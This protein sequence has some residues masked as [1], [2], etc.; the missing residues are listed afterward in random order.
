[1]SDFS[2]FTILEALHHM[3]AAPHADWVA[4]DPK[5][6]LGVGVYALDT[7]KVYIGDG[8]KTYTQLNPIN[9]QAI[10]PEFK[11]MLDNAGLANG[12]A[13]L[14]ALGKVDMSNIPGSWEHMTVLYMADIAARDAYPVE[15]RNDK[16]F[17][18]MDASADPT[19]N[20]GAAVYGWIDPIGEPDQ[21][22][23]VKIMEKESLDVD[24]SDLLTLSDGTMDMILAGTNYVH[25]TPTMRAKLATIEENADVTDTEN[26]TAAGA[27]MYPIDTVVNP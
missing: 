6:P 1:M 2:D 26:V 17:Y 8:V 21:D 10:T 4:A 12:V 18:V 22:E 20:L 9:D 14:D 13:I 15:K 24:L 11:D 19:V 25:F 16:L 3:T 5:I 23:W 27:L 7:K